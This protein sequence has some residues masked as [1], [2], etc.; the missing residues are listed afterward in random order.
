MTIA[1]FLIALSLYAPGAPTNLDTTATLTLTPAFSWIFTD[2]DY[3]DEQRSF[4]IIVARTGSDLEMDVANLWDSGKVTSNASGITYNGT[5]LERGQ[6]AY[7][8]VKTWDSADTE[9]PWSAPRPFTI[10]PFAIPPD[11]QPPTMP[12]GLTRVDSSPTDTTPSFSWNPSNDN[13]AVAYYALNVGPYVFANLG[14]ATTFTLPPDKPLAPMQYVVE[15]RAR[16]TSENSSPAALL[17][18][19]IM[20]LLTSSAPTEVSLFPGTFRAGDVV[21][22]PDDRNPE[23]TYDSTLYFL[24]TN[25]KR[26][27]FPSDKIYFSWYPDFS[28]VKTISGTDLA[29]IS[30]GGNV[31]YRPGV[32]MIKLQSAPAVYVILR[33]GT[34]RALPHESVARALYGQNWNQFIDDLPDAFWTHYKLSTSLVS[35]N[36]YS[37]LLQTNT[38][39][40]IN[41][42]LIL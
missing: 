5:T 7:W 37:P 19:T 8:K 34:L 17:T 31:R 21:K 30:L 42:D 11:R 13:Q 29:M 28:N 3:S 22:L 15:V 27:V 20:E 41:L 14:L 9:G 38:T 23:T 33:G 10:S 25:G 16:D 32:R 26:Y 39:P 24:N 35:E 2:P 18:F 6:S 4:R 36:E 1:A 40:S 12:S